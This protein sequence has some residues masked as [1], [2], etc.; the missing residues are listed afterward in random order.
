M[1]SSAANPATRQQLAILIRQYLNRQISS[2][3]F[4]ANLDPFWAQAEDQTV[5]KIARSLWFHYDDLKNRMVRLSREQW[6]YMQRLLLILHTP[7]HIIQ[8]VD[9]ASPVRQLGAAIGLIVFFA[10]A[11]RGSGLLLL[12]VY[13]LL[14]PLA[15]WLSFQRRQKRRQATPLTPF[16]SLAE[17]RAAYRC[18]AGFKKV[19]YPQY[20]KSPPRRKIWD[21]SIIELPWWTMSVFFSPL[22]LISHLWP[23][24]RSEVRIVRGF[25]MF[26][27]IDQSAIT[28][29]D[30]TST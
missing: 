28:A 21:R 30:A 25:P 4:D 2:F 29:R 14:A 1:N 9:P 5:R 13:F 18:A 23:E 27:E 19:Q 6:N 8:T 11:T 26:E 16:A 17:L 24:W 10:T 3:R 15:F 20:L 7:A 12:T 22:A